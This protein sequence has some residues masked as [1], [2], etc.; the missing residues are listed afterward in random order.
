MPPS[1]ESSTTLVNNNKITKIINGRYLKNGQ[2]VENDYLWIREGKF[3]DPAQLFY[4]EKSSPEQ[5]IDAKGA[6]V[7]PGFIELQLNGKF[8][9]YKICDLLRAKLTSLI[10]LIYRCLWC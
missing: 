9:N 3:V 6:L 1:V 2:I 7:V 4:E 8:E 5:I 10:V